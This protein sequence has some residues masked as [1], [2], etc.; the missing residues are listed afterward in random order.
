MTTIALFGAGGKIGTRIAN[1]LRNDPAY[2]MLYL[3]AGEAGLARLRERGL[4]PASREEAMREADVVILATPVRTIVK[5][6]TEIGPLLSPGSL[7]TD[8]GSAKQ[9]VVQAMQALPSHVQ[10]IGGHPMCG[11][12]TSGLS[13]AD[14]SLYESATYVLTPLSRTSE[15]A[16]R[17]AIELVRAVGAQP[18]L[19]DAS[20]HD[21]LVAATSHLPYLLSVGLVGTVERLADGAA[22]KVV[23]GG[24]RDTSRLAASDETMM[25]DTLLANRDMVLTA[26]A[27]FQDRLSALAHLLETGNEADLR[28][29][30]ATAAQRRKGLFR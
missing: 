19:L 2:H 8:M 18:L 15:S 10:P 16:M 22:W 3:E 26:L 23:A 12:E 24:F 30:M 14:A 5:I 7:L 1:A 6:L 11:K 28:C 20:R 27:G 9:E 29:A 4:E 25:L 21:T 17:L 13:A